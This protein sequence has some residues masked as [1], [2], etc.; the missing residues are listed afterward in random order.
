MA[1]RSVE[2]ISEFGKSGSGKI[3]QKALI[4]RYIP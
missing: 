2:Y 4:E 1:P 3:Y